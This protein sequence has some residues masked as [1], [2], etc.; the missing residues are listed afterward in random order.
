[1]SYTRLHSTRTALFCARRSIS[2]LSWLL[3]LQVT[4]AKLKYRFFS[5]LQHLPR[6]VTT[7]PVPILRLQHVAC[8]VRFQRKTECSIQSARSGRLRGGHKVRPRPFFHPPP[9][10]RI[11]DKHFFCEF[12]FSDFVVCHLSGL[13]SLWSVWFNSSAGL[14]LLCRR[15]LS[16]CSFSQLLWFGTERSPPRTP[17][18]RKPGGRRQ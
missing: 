7:P 11:T 8:T 14:V 1:M 13:P 2:R 4:Q 16:C 17:C 5:M 15:S 3:G 10:R 9:S 12:I 6:S 18:G